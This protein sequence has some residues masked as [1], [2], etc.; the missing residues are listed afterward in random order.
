MNITEKQYHDLRAAIGAVMGAMEIIG[1]SLPTTSD[2]QFFELLQ[3][4]AAEAMRILE[5][6]GSDAT[7]PN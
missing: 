4:N 2:K 1:I 7:K 3:R 6:V 5:E